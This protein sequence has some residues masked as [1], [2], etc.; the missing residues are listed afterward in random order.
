MFPLALLLFTISHRTGLSLILCVLPYKEEYDQY[1]GVSLRKDREFAWWDF[2]VRTRKIWPWRLRCALLRIYKIGICIM[3]WVL[4]RNERS[5]YKTPSV[6]LDLYPHHS[7]HFFA[8]SKNNQ[9]PSDVFSCVLLFQYD[10]LN[11]RCAKVFRKHNV[12]PWCFLDRRKLARLQWVSFVRLPKEHTYRPCHGLATIGQ[13][14]IKCSCSWWLVSSSHPH[15]PLL[16]MRRTLVHVLL[17]SFLFWNEKWQIR[18]WAE[19]STEHN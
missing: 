19:L 5:V 10:I 11:W 9:D 2:A 15:C 12:V 4:T 18:K 13:G 17:S 7:L 14:Y 16:K 6:L 8:V 1:M 3:W